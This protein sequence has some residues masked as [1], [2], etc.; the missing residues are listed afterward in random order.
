MNPLL[1]IISGPSG[2]GKDAILE[3][4]RLRR[5]D[6]FYAVTATTRPMRNQEKN[7][8]DY[9]FLDENEFNKL[10]MQGEFLEHAEVYGNHYGVPK[11]P[12]RDAIANS[13]NAF[14]KIDVQGARTIRSITE[15][16]LLIFVAPPSLIELERR[17]KDRKA[18]SASQ[19]EVRILTA[20]YEMEQSN[21]FDFVVINQ[22]GQLE[23]TV[24][25]ILKIVAAE[26][27]RPDSR[28]ISI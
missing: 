14:I 1:V 9:I 4:L 23:D 28:S 2:V 21:M 11:K 15:D 25:Q 16:A 20:K 24:D 17:L 26:Q 12:I 3:Q 13:I 10:L 27:Y 18:D 6:F 19:M 7:G 22:T 5:P 8:I